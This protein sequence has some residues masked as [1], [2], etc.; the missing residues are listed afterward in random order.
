M[1]TYE[2]V[3]ARPRSSTV[4]M[5]P[6][7]FAG[8]WIWSDI[9]MRLHAHGFGTIRVHEP[10]A[11]HDPVVPLDSFRAPLI[12]IVDATGCGPVVI[13]GNSLGGL[14]A[15]DLAVSAP[16]RVEAVVVSGA[17]GLGE[18]PNL[19]VGTPRQLTRGWARGLAAQLFYDPMNITD[20]MIDRAFDVVSDRRVL[21]N[22]VRALRAARDFDLETVLPRIHA[23]S[24][25]LWGEHDRVTPLRPWRVHLD[26]LRD[27]RLV[28]VPRSGHAPMLEQPGLFADHLLAFLADVAASPS[29]LDPRAVALGPAA[30]S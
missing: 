10:L 12:E 14:I 28:V 23:P 7:L 5:L 9:A 2:H 30:S 26:R 24:L 6:G 3:A 27:H 15:L 29:A 18:A 25:L 11:A 17:P 13:C 1:F 4:L 16:Q 22:I 21:F 8:D 19:G 20:A